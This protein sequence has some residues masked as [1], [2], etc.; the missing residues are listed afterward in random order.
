MEAEKRPLG[1]AQDLQAVQGPDAGLELFRDFHGGAD[2][3]LVAVPAHGLGGGP[4]GGNGAPGPGPQQ[5]RGGKDAPGP[6]LVDEKLVFEVIHVPVEEHRGPLGGVAVFVDVGGDGGDPGDLEI[7]G[8]QGIG[9]S[10][11]EGKEESAHAGIHVERNIVGLGQF[12]QF[13][14]GIDDA[15][16]VIGGRGHDHGRVAVDLFA[17]RLHIHLQARIQGN[18]DQLD[19]EVFGRF[20][21]GHVD[22]FRNDHFRPDAPQ[23]PFFQ[24]PFPVGQHR[25]EAGFRPPGGEDA[26]GVVVPAQD[27]GG[28]AHHLVLKAFEAFEGH[29]IE[30]VFR[31]KE[32]VGLFEEIRV[33]LPQVVDQGPGATFLVI[34]I[35]GA[36]GFHFLEDVG[37]GASGVGQ[38]NHGLSPWNHD[39]IKALKT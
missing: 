20:H 14:N 9:L 18:G 6:V 2:L 23:P 10:V 24:G 1:D 36:E 17:H 28:H 37:V 8:G 25:E 26:H 29:G 22:G 12:P 11:H 34:H 13:F 3:G 4:G 38:G 7:I 35:P 33:F 39:P 30:A 16:G 32:A 21:P 19:I 31:E 5:G 27:V 15:V